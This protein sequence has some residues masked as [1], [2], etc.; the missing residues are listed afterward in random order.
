MWGGPQESTTWWL[1]GSTF[2]HSFST[3]RILT[4]SERSYILQAQTKKRQNMQKKLGN[5]RK[6]GEIRQE[7]ILYKNIGKNGVSGNRT[8]VFH[9]ASYA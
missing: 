4:F 7:K 5:M 3:D 6:K 1:K 8:Y 9:T 2:G